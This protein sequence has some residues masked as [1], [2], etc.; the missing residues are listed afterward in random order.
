MG[1]REG[2]REGGR[3]EGKEKEERNGTSSC[4]RQRLSPKLTE[5]E[6]KLCKTK[7]NKMIN[8]GKMG[9]GKKRKQ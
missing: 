9:N 4:V 7:R 1:E 5:E 8:K 6:A 2:G 3:K